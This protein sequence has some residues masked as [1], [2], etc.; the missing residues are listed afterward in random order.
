MGLELMCA[1]EQAREGAP[2]AV[3]IPC[4]MVPSGPPSSSPPD[5][6]SY[7]P[8]LGRS[9]GLRVDTV[10]E[11]IAL[12]PI[13]LEFRARIPNGKKTALP[14]APQRRGGRTHPRRLL[15]ELGSFYE[16]VVEVKADVSGLGCNPTGRLG[17]GKRGG[18]QASVLAPILD[19]SN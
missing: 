5:E 19:S 17:D 11:P 13:P 2:G 8:P 9:C 14:G 6:E 18:A 1:L 3:L 12:L 15:V 4:V 7:A 10:R 16:K